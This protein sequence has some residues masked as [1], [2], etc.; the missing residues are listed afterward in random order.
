[1]WNDRAIYVT[2]RRRVEDASTRTPCADAKV[3]D[4]FSNTKS[5]YI[6]LTYQS[7]I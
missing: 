1:M 6:V 5:L 3:E 7:F 2:T 4:E